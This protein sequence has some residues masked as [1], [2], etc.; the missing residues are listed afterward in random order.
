MGVLKG[1]VEKLARARERYRGGSREERQAKG[2]AN[3]SCI[4]HNPLFEDGRV[5]LRD[6]GTAD[7]SKVS[8]PEEDTA[9]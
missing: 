2:R 8:S 6:V 5:A 4:P 7:P 3:R 9:R 1:L